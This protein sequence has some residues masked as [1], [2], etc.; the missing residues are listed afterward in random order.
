VREARSPREAS[1][2]G[3]VPPVGNDKGRGN[4]NAKG[5]VGGAEGGMVA[6]ADGG[7]V[8]VAGARGGDV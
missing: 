5:S 4:P 8:A 1:S 3:D 2:D 6:A 7:M